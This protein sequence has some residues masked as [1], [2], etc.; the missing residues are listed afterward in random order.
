MIMIIIAGRVIDRLIIIII[1]I[2]D[3]DHDLIVGG[4]ID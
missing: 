3:Y 2:D 1:T 4:V